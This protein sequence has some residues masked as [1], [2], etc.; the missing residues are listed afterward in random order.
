M[1]LFVK[2]NDC[3]HCG[4]RKKKLVTS[5]SS[6]LTIL[7]PANGLK[8]DRFKTFVAKKVYPFTSPNNFNLR[9]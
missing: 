9:Y 6:H 2:R 5:V 7:L 1:A 3:Q 8:L 4:E